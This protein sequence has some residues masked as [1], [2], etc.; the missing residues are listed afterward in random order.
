MIGRLALPITTGATGN[1]A[2]EVY[3]SGRDASR[4]D[5]HCKSCQ[6]AGQ[7]RKHE[8][9]RKPSMN[10]SCQKCG[11]TDIHDE[12]FNALQGGFLCKSCYRAFQIKSAG[13]GILIAVVGLFVS[14]LIIAAVTLWWMLA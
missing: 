12:A 6:P 1:F 13:I 7:F 3:K 10:L 4:W 2:D 8:S 5:S 9:I 11:K 14:M